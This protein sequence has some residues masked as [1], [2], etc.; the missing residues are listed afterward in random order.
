MHV[1]AVSIL[2][3]DVP[4]QEAFRIHFLHYYSAF[5]LSRHCRMQ[6]LPQ[7]LQEAAVFTYLC[8]YIWLLS[9]VCKGGWYPE[10]QHKWLCTQLTSEGSSRATHPH[11]VRIWTLIPH[12]I[13]PR[14]CDK[15]P[16]NR[17]V[18]HHTM[19]GQLPPAHRGPAQPPQ[20][21]P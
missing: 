13:I 14:A 21:P 5:P 15:G 1:S 18:S 11:P 3:P 19:G 7:A 9:L 8:N 17:D 16:I 6:Q 2:L 4:Y 12:M 10:T 20:Q